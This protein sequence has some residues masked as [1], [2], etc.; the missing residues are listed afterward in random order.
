M[1]FSNGNI[2]A[3]IDTNGKLVEGEQQHKAEIVQVTYLGA[4]YLQFLV[5]ILE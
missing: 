4:Q 3:K 1:T 5:R 2:I